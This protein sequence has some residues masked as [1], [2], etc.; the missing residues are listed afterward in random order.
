MTDSPRYTPAQILEMGRRAEHEGN[1]EY[2]TQFYSYIADNLA[3]APEAVD[4]R[5]ALDRLTHLHQRRPEPGP[6]RHQHPQS[7]PAGYE[8]VPR[9]GAPAQPVPEPSLS[10]PSG[11]IAPPSTADPRQQGVAPVQHPY[12]QPSAAPPAG[13][14][15]AYQPVPHMAQSGSDGEEEEAEFEPGYRLG[16]F[17]AFTLQ[18]IGWLVLLGGLIFIALNLAGVVASEIVAPISGL[19]G[20]VVLGL[21][22]VAAGLALVFIG[23]FAQATFESA[24]NTRE[25]LEIERAKAGW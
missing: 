5:L 22:A 1:L 10:M 11:H 13:H 19:P 8:E 2:A 23:L 7:A 3:G 4:A 18:L 12:G 17:L 9:T 6:V 16:R 20:G 14:T 25:L 15:N 24:N 21:G